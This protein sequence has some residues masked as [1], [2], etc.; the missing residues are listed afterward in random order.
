MNSWNCK[1]P[2]F[3][4]FSILLLHSVRTNLIS[5]SQPNSLSYVVPLRVET[6]FC[7]PK[8]QQVQYITIQNFVHF[9]FTYIVD[10]RVKHTEL[11]FI[12]IELC[13]SFEGFISHHLLRHCF[14]VCLWDVIIYLHTYN[15]SLFVVHRMRLS[16]SEIVGFQPH[17]HKF[18][19]VWLSTL[20]LLFGVTNILNKFDLFHNEGLNVSS[21][22]ISLGDADR[23][24][25]LACVNNPVRSITFP[26]EFS[27]PNWSY[28]SCKLSPNVVEAN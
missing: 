7:R 3:A 25:F 17:K 2:H 18:H 24:M 14:A 11:W 6:K 9:N 16:V 20:L 28:F 10:G 4:L 21:S 8:K 1:A 23:N 12:N 22:L 5:M 13:R 27:A 19:D 15:N 26:S